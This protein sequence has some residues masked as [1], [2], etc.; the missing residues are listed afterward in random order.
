MKYFYHLALPWFYNSSK[1]VQFQEVLSELKQTQD[2]W[3]VQLDE[4]SNESTAPTIPICSSL[5]DCPKF[6]SALDVVPLLTTSPQKE[7]LSPT[8]VAKPPPVSSANSSPP[9]SMVVA[10]DF[11][12]QSDV[13]VNPQRQMRLFGKVAAA[14]GVG[15]I[16]LFCALGHVGEAAD[17]LLD[18]VTTVHHEDIFDF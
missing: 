18:L 7:L 11:V 17:W 4:N 2:D 3:A 1:N 15:A 12:L 13:G 14:A 10:A 6:S 16:L 9:S 5:P 8:P